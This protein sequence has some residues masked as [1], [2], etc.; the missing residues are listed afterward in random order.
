MT[1]GAS[2]NYATCLASRVNGRRALWRSRV[3]RL[4]QT[5]E[6]RELRMRLAEA[7]AGTDAT[8][9]KRL[10]ASLRRNKQLEKRV[11]VPSDCGH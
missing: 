1:R 7:E 8:L 6:L 9:K 5:E 2:C 10:D 4:C 3:C 11:R